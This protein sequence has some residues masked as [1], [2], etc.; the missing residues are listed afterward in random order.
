MNEIMRLPLNFVIHRKAEEEETFNLRDN[1]F[2]L[3]NNL[4]TN[5][6]SFTI[7]RN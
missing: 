5:N 2:V 6:I 1:H 4:D 7:K 3:T